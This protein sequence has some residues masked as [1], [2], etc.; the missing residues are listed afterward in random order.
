M[1]VIESAG[2]Q[3]TQQERFEKVRTLI[4]PDSASACAELAADVAQ[5]I[6]TKADTGETAVLGLATGSTPVPLYRE[7]IRMHRD[8]GLSFRN[9]VTFNLDEYYGLEADHRESYARFMNEQ[10]FAH[11]DIPDE[12]VNIPDGTV[13]LD[14]VYDSCM[15]YEEK[16]RSVGGIDL[17]ILGIGR[18]GHNRLQRA[19]IERRFKDAHDHSGPS[20]PSRRGGRFP[21]RGERAALRDHDGGGYHPGGAAGSC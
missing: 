5:L 16:I 9:V 1:N 4:Y 8:E 20:D 7:L 19:G 18:T 10:L 13:G 11:I 15:A 3:Q 17:Q 6:R 21:R 12:N 14:E 2:R